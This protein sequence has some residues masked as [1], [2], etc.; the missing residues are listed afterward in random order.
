MIILSPS[1]S[2][3]TNM[4]HVLSSACLCKDLLADEE[5]LLRL[6]AT[7]ELLY[8]FFQILQYACNQQ[9]F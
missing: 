8:R 4:D 9:W 2:S 3:T 1:L 6:V 5:R 7:S